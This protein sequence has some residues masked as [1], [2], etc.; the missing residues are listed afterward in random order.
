MR[1][2]GFHPGYPAVETK[3]FYQKKICSTQTGTQKY[4]MQYQLASL[5][6]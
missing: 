6:I 3:T 2:V 1:N 4:K 5:P